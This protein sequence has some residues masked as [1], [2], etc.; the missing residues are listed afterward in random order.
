M[1]LMTKIGPPIKLPI[2]FDGYYCIFFL[3]AT[4]SIFYLYFKQGLLEI[5]AQK[6]CSMK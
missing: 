6:S 5:K 4:F 1:P 3:R 2:T